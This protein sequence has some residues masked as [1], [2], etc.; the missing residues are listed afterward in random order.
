MRPT[1]AEHADDGAG[2]A[3]PVLVWR[4][5]EPVRCLASTVLG[6]GLGERR[7]LL[8]ATVTLGYR[9][10]DPAG[11]AARIAAS[12][13][14]ETGAGAA[15][16]TGVDVRHFEA[17]HDE[18]VDVVATVG[19]GAV[20]WAAAPAG[21]YELW[22]PGTVNVVAW[23]PVAL[24]D[25]ALVNL[26]ATIAEAK[27]Q[28]FAEAGVPGT[29]TPSDA[30]A[31]CCPTGTPPDVDDHRYGGPRSTWGSRVARAAHLAIRTGIGA[32]R[33]RRTPPAG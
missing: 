5:P 31:V 17:A 10:D 29:G 9:E 25:A 22:Q 7:W 20:T 27:A 28:A 3:G 30:V 19:L 8:N 4:F 2:Q 32:D 16:L 15:L 14:L 18:G 6:G 26:V 23:V 1:V 33:P 12:C 11:H 21:Q 24:H 13:G